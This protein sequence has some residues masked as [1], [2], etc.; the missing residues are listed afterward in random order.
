MIVFLIANKISSFGDGDEE[1]ERGQREGE[2]KRGT[3]RRWT[4][5]EREVLVISCVVALVN[6]T[7]SPF[8]GDTGADGQFVPLSTLAV[9]LHKHSVGALR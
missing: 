9:F 2:Q 3:E 7:M 1:E 6:V 8:C 4:G 5:E